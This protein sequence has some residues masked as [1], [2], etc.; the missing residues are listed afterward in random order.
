MGKGFAEAFVFLLILC[1]LFIPLGLWKFIEILM[2]VFKH[3]HW[4]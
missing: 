3:I 4:S 1:V 2:W